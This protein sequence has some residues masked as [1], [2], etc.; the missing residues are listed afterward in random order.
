MEGK[1][2]HILA[3]ET[4]DNKTQ[5]TVELIA[6]PPANPPKEVQLADTEVEIVIEPK[7]FR[8]KLGKENDGWFEVEFQPKAPG[9]YKL[10]VRLPETGDTYLHKFLVKESNPELDNVKP[11]FEAMYKP[12]Q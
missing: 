1:E 9:E 12:G 2:G 8:D 3:T 5:V 4:K 11:D 10:Q 7:K 6:N